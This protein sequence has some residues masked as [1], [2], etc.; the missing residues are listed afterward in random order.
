M[1]T[2]KPRSRR[3][4]KKETKDSNEYKQ[5]YIDELLKKVSEL[6][7]ELKNKFKLYPAPLP[8]MDTAEGYLFQIPFSKM[9]D[10]YKGFECESHCVFHALYVLG[11]RS[12]SL[13]IE[14]SNRLFEMY[15]KNYASITNHDIGKYLST[16]YETNISVKVHKDN[17]LPYL[18]IKEGYATLVSLQT[19]NKDDVSLCDN[20][21][22]MYG[23]IIIIY[24]YNSVIY[25]YNPSSQKN[26]V[27]INEILEELN[28]YRIEE[29]ICF[30]KDSYVASL[31]R[32]KMVAPIM[33]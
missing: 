24:K 5:K 7:S 11:L 6:K 8:K 19:Y 1:T 33:Y 26:T 20:E 9:I 21:K 2:S 32:A 4:E 10:S 23:T 15:D 13:C 12:K 18:D 3:K 27:S 30:Y 31:N 14:D 22:S 25:C 29:Y 17:K 16:I 28:T